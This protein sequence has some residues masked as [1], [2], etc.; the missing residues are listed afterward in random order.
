MLAA[1]GSVSLATGE[2][3]WPDISLRLYNPH[4]VVEGLVN[5]TLDI[6]LTLNALGGD[7][8]QQVQAEVYGGTL[9]LTIN[10]HVCY[11]FPERISQAAL[12]WPEACRRAV[13][14]IRSARGSLCFVGG[15]I[16]LPSLVEPSPAQLS[17]AAFA[18][19]GTVVVT[20]PHSI[21]LASPH[22]MSNPRPSPDK[23]TLVLTLALNVGR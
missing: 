16:S 9:C 15:E 12:F 3:A 4:V 21:F 14:A 2:I 7:V 20:S 13:E 5:N 11:C 10:A 18:P 6:G 23:L 19:P 1:I 8:S 22:S 17:G